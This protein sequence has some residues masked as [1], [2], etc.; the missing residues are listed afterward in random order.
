MMIGGILD[1]YIA[2]A[3]IGGSLVVLMVFISLELIFAFVDE[4]GDIGADYTALQALVHVGLSAPQRAYEAFPIA[5]LIGSLMTLGGLAARS[6]LV[7]MRAA[8]V[9][10]LGIGRAVVL[11][12]LVLAALS[13]ALGEF[14]APQAERL[15][16]DIRAQAR[17]GTVSSLSENGFWVRDGRDFLSVGS[18]P[19]ARNLRDLRIYTFRD[20]G[21][22]DKVTKAEH[23]RYMG[24]G[25]WALEGVVIDAFLERGVD[26]RRLES[27][28][29]QSSLGPEVLD[30]VVLDPE[31]LSMAELWTYIGYLERNALESE[32]YRLAFWL[33]V[34]T[35]LATLTML[36]LTIPL[37]FG[38]LRSVGAGQRIFIGVMIGVVFYLAN[39]VLNHMG[40]VYGLPPALSALLP[41]LVFLAIA[42]VA[43]S[44]VR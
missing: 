10:I 43:A 23:A 36:L 15:A 19:D 21:R 25:R 3:V 7:V 28:D 8:G 18:A 22:M 27:M 34:V 29:W 35:P 42:L 32:R 13:A 38:S 9:S 11:A 37:V 26:S 14:V 31:M 44:R 6:E 4:S 20:D 39:R 16:Q 30:V 40:V 33:K 2:R 5:T 41:T 12:G 17:S 1:R 24:P